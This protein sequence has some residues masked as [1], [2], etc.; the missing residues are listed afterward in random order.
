MLYRSDLPL[1]QAAGAL[2]AK[3]TED[4]NGIRKGKFELWHRSSRHLPIVGEYKERRADGTEISRKAIV[5]KESDER[6]RQLPA[7]DINLL[8]CFQMLPGLITKMPFHKIPRKLVRGSVSHLRD[9]QTDKETF[10]VVVHPD[11]GSLVKKLYDKVSIAGAALDEVNV[12]H[13]GNTFV[14]VHTRRK[15]WPQYPLHC[16]NGFNS[17]CR[18]VWFFSGSSLLNEFGYL[19]TSLFICGNLARYY[20]DRWIKEIEKSSDLAIAISAL[21][22]LATERM[23]VLAL[24]EMARVYY[25][26]GS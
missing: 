26:T 25:I 14:V 11:D 20:P 24:S 9:F 4:A 23:A 22:N 7:K 21:L 6:L 2:I 8:E 19:Y 12:E 1:T 5:L 17:D 18:L 15:C 3:P 10:R 16:P 13:G